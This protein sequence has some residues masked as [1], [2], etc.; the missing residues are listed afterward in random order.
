MPP[1]IRVTIFIVRLA[2]DDLGFDVRCAHMI[3]RHDALPSLQAEF[4]S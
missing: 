2:I 1:S 3:G 4:M